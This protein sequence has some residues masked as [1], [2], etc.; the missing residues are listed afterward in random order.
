MAARRETRNGELTHSGQVRCVRL[1][2]LQAAVR[3]RGKSP[4]RRR[5]GQ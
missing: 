3:S 2:R 5:R 4:R 1:R